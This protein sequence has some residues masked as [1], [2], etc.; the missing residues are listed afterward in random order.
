[1]FASFDVLNSLKGLATPEVLTVLGGLT[2]LYVGFKAT[3]KVAG[4]AVS[5]ASKVSVLGLIAT[6]LTLGG[7]TVSGLGM[8][9]LATRWSEK[10]APVQK[11]GISDSA[12]VDLATKCG[13]DAETMKLVLDYTKDR[14]GSRNE[15]GEARLVARL[16]EKTV[17]D[18]KENSDKAVVAFIEYLN[19][20]QTNKNNTFDLAIA[21]NDP[22]AINNMISVGD[23]QTSKT[24]TQK[25]D[26][27]MSIPA[28]LGMMGFGLGA[29]VCGM[30]VYRNFRKAPAVQHTVASR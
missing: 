29:I 19:R 17:D 15:V 22:A 4:F 1:M 2:A 21:S 13:H 11:S 3:Q 14:D 6:I 10:P 27:V 25:K 8:G 7:T 18:K 20:K 12:L 23:E 24:V 28:S 30:F 26:S 16:V 9:E 5:M